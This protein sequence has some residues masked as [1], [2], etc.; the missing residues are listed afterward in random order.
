MHLHPG[1]FSLSSVCGLGTSIDHIP[2]SPHW[3]VPLAGMV[4]LAEADWFGRGGS[5]SLIPANS[6]LQKAWDNVICSKQF[7]TIMASGSDVSRVRP[8]F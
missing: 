2:S 1:Q 6:T 5:D 7:E 3:A 4:T 8:L